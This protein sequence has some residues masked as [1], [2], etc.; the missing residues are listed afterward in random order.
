[1]V[2]H[3]YYSQTKTKLVTT[4]KQNANHTYG[5]N[6]LQKQNKQAH[7]KQVEDMK[8]SESSVEGI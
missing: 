2:Q 6:K 1:M 5:T 8:I 4:D 3:N 7:L